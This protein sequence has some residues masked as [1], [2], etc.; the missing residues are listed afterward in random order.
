MTKNCK[1]SNYLV[2]KN[3]KVTTLDCLICIR[4]SGC[5]CSY[6]SANHNQTENWCAKIWAIYAVWFIVCY[7]EPNEY[8]SLY[9][10]DFEAEERQAEAANK[11]NVNKQ[12]WYHGFP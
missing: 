2:V 11:A 3:Y 6:D 9:W 4:Q 1:I 12:M 7:K 10:F 5:I 8:R